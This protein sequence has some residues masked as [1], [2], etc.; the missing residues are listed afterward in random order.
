[1]P[2]LL[3]ILFL[4]FSITAEAQR[5]PSL[6]PYRKGKLWGYADTM[7]K[8]VIAPK[9]DRCFPFVNGKAICEQL[10]DKI[11]QIDS[12]GKILQTLPYKMHE[13]MGEACIKISRNYGKEGVLGLDGSFVVPVKYDNVEMLGVDSFQ[14]I[15]PGKRGVIN[16]A[17]K[18]LVPFEPY[19]WDETMSMLETFPDASCETPCFRAPYREGMALAAHKGL[20]GYADTSR[21]LKIPCKYHSGESFYYGLARILYETPGQ[22]KE[23]ARKDSNGVMIVKAIT[24]EDGYIDKLGNEYWED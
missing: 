15:V 2:R 7:K 6:I 16:S 13:Y 8:I 4:L 23:P 17:G 10:D 5:R 12:T 1:M 14:V 19:Q 3:L 11:V 18:I 24:L 20:F 22:K 9:Y 21:T